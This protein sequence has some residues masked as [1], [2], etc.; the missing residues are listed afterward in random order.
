M[1]RT[2]LLLCVALILILATGCASMTSPPVSRHRTD[3]TAWIDPGA[4]LY[5][6]VLPGLDAH[7]EGRCEFRFEVLD[8]ARLPRP[9][10]ALHGEL[11]GNANVAAFLTVG[12]RF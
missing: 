5:E 8:S 6:R 3:L 12:F 1:H 7:R 11:P 9:V 2:H 10:Q 4:G